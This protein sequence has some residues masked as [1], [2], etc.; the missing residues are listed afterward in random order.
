MPGR[1]LL[2]S[3]RPS[4][5][6]PRS[7]GTSSTPFGGR[8]ADLPALDCARTRHDLQA[9]RPRESSPWLAGAQPVVRQS[10]SEARSALP[11]TFYADRTAGQRNKPPP[12][13]TAAATTTSA[14][15]QH[16]RQNKKGWCHRWR[17]G[18]A[19]APASTRT[20]R[21]QHQVPANASRKWCR[22]VGMSKSRREAGAEPPSEPS[23]KSLEQLP[24]KG[25]RHGPQRPPPDRASE[26]V[27][28]SASARPPGEQ[29]YHGRGRRPPAGR[30]AQ[31]QQGSDNSP[32][33]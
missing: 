24:S 25:E 27:H 4:A 17:T 9:E 3:G 31:R 10:R 29:G 30:P 12:R 6:P 21:R 8:T 22:Y 26:A 23:S 20:A 11:R 18:P 13:P 32:G 33:S 2:K 16:P 19:V 15:A 1:E 7:T 5:R 28:L 14:E